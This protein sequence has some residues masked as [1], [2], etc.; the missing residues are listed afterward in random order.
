MHRC[1]FYALTQR[2]GKD[3]CWG[4]VITPNFNACASR[5]QLA[6]RGIALMGVTDDAD[7]LNERAGLRIF[8]SKLAPAGIG[9]SR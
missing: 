8:A 5:R 1:A 2:S 4:F 7:C 3:P 6:P 9:A